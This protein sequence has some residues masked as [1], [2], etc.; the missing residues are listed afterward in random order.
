MVLRSTQKVSAI[1]TLVLD[2]LQ[3]A[4]R[5]PQDQPDGS[6]LPDCDLLS[7]SQQHNINMEAMAEGSVAMCGQ[8]SPQCFML[9]A[10]LCTEQC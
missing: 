7:S 10:L 3:G 4:L 1:H 2:L 6:A 8:L 5:K 9:Y